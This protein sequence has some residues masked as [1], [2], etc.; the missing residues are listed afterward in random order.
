M[1]LR[2]SQNQPPSQLEIISEVVED[3]NTEAFCFYAKGPERGAIG[4]SDANPS[5]SFESEAE[6]QKFL[7]AFHLFELKEK[8]QTPPSEIM[9]E[10]L[11]MYNANKSK[12]KEAFSMGR[13]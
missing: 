1:P 3:P 12:W 5:M 9:R 4:F 10:A 11:D 2:M 7:L 13:S 8:Y 6:A